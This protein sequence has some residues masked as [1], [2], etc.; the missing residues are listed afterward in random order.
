MSETLKNHNQSEI[1]KTLYFIDSFKLI[2]FFD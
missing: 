1:Y 2:I